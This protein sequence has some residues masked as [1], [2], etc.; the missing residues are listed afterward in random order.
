[1]SIAN[2]DVTQVPTWRHGYRFQFEAAQN[3]HVILYPEG[4]IQ[5]NESAS[6]IGQYIDG[7]KSVA[8]IIAQL[9]QKFGDIEAIGNDVIEYMLVAEQEHWIEFK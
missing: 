1:M 9:K 8:E 2:F 5:L 6:A 4:M 3:R 7:E